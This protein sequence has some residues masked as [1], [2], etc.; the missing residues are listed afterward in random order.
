MTE[1]KDG[2]IQGIYRDQLLNGRA[3]VKGGQKDAEVTETEMLNLGMG[4]GAEGPH[5]RMPTKLSVGNDTTDSKHKMLK[6][7]NRYLVTQT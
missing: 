3:A 2:I 4:G 1:I 7:S 6:K 5:E